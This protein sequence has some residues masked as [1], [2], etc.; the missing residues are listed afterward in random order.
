MLPSLVLLLVCFVLGVLARRTGRFPESTPSALNA[1]VLQVALPA[2]VL[3]VM[4]SLQVEPALLLAASAPWLVF[5]G[6]AGAG[7]WA[8]RRGWLPAPTAGAL[9]LTAGL[10]NTAF[11]GL[12]MVE[13]F[14]GAAGLGIAVVVDQLG[15]FLV[16]STLALVLA[17]RLAAQRLSPRTL[18][19]RV[20]L[21]PPFLAL[22]VGVALRPLDFPAWL[23]TV[24]HRIGDTLTPLALFSVGWQLRLSALR[25]RAGLLAVGLGYKLALA[26]ALVAEVLRALGASGLPL[27]VAVVQAAMAPMVTGSILAMEYKLEPELAA[28]MVGV[29]VPLSFVTA[30]LVWQLMG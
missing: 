25:G 10:G 15:S 28:L 16:L 23:D 6:A 21:F 22:L 26:P 19:T 12:P 18:V 29:G 1:W 3:R 11:V 2:L 13:G 27:R 4:H 24:L 17:T 5:L 30:P 20:V 7:L 14:A 9:I 8:V